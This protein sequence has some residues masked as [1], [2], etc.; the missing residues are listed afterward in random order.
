MEFRFRGNVERAQE[1]LRFGRCG[2]VSELVND[3]LQPA[4][5]DLSSA[6][7]QEQSGNLQVGVRRSGFRTA[8]G[9]ENASGF[10]FSDFS[11]IRQFARDMH[12]SMGTR[13]L[14]IRKIQLSAI[15]Y[16]DIRESGFLGPLQKSQAE[17][18][19]RLVDLRTLQMP[20]NFG[21]MGK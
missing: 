18:A 19:L 4:A 15:D 9:G 21:V 1:R 7:S 20:G 8:S 10:Q 12:L 6:I 16:F 14:S 5:G 11:S 17:V 2:G 3:P 13:G